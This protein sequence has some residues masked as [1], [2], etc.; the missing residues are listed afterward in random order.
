M[1][2]TDEEKNKIEFRFIHGDITIVDWSD[3]DVIFANSTCF[4]DALMEK[5]TKQAEKT[6]TGTFMLTTT[7]R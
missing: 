5:V 3:G 6:R 1:M 7:N 4:D 2:L